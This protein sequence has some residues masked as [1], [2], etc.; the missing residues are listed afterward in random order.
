MGLVWAI[1]TIPGVLF[2]FYTLWMASSS[3]GLNTKQMMQFVFFFIGYR[4]CTS[5]ST[6]T[7][8]PLCVLVPTCSACVALVCT[9]RAAGDARGCAH[10]GLGP[11]SL[12]CPLQTDKCSK[13]FAVNE[14]RR[15]HSQWQCAASAGWRVHANVAAVA[16]PPPNPVSRPSF[17]RVPPGMRSIHP[18]KWHIRT[19]G[20]CADG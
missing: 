20:T 10:D 1:S 19:R 18:H 4:C 11:C 6:A 16:P 15:A 3:W 5:D 17:C 2:R 13:G 14:H 9:P 8:A 7:A 12:R